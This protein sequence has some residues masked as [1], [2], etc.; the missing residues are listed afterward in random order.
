MH[1]RMIF[2]LLFVALLS[3]AL[4]LPAAAQEAPPAEPP[5]YTFGGSITF[6]YLPP[7]DMTITNA[8]IF[9]QEVEGGI[10][11]IAG[12]ATI[13]EGQATY[14]LDLNKNSL[15]AFSEVEYWFEITPAEQAPFATPHQRFF[16]ED[17]RFTWQT[18]EGGPFRVHW[19]EGDVSV[20][21]NVLNAAQAGLERARLL[22]GPIPDPQITNIYVYASGQELQSALR[23]GGLTWVAG[24]ADPDLALVM[25]SLPTGPDQKRETERQIPHELMHIFMYQI[26]GDGYAYIPTW[27]KEGVA[28]ANELRPNADYYVILNN[29]VGKD[30]LIPLIN[31]CQ[32]FPKDANVYLAYAEADSFVRYLHQQYGANGLSAMMTSYAGGAGCEVGSQPAVG[33]TLTQ[34]ERSWQR[35]VLGQEVILAALES[36]LPWLILLAVVLVAPVILTVANLRSRKHQKEKAS[37]AA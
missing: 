31:L 26:T 19:Y 17:N 23:L 21:Q 35:E 20:G 5:P 10:E 12:T 4:A 2:P 16:Y 1:H 22:L 18:L 9:I 6:T 28:S 32:S 8:E 29:A 13:S 33:S 27:F 11:S 25:V 30:S 7:A 24:H 36:L 34:L 37:L 15:R 14:I 3:L